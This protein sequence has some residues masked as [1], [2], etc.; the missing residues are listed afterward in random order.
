VFEVVDSACQ[1]LNIVRAQL[2]AFQQRSVLQEAKLGCST[3]A[4]L[5]KLGV[6][7]VAAKIQ[8]R[9]RPD[10]DKRFF[11][12]AAN[13]VVAQVED[14]EIRLEDRLKRTLLNSIF[15]ICILIKLFVPK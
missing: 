6:E 9:E 3:A 14:F 13:Q 1:I 8:V 7:L 15:K 12:H 10:A 11:V 2:E 5:F 4:I